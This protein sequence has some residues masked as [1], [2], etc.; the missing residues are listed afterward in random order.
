[1]A[2]VLKRTTSGLLQGNQNDA[3]IQDLRAAVDF[4]EARVSNPAT[5]RALRLDRA[6]QLLAESHRAS[7]PLTRRGGR[8]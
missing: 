8:R 3:S 5:R 4:L 6:S 1:M 7:I 2:A